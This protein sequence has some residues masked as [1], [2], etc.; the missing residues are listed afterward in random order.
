[1]WVFRLFRRSKVADDLAGTIE[2][3]EPLLQGRGV[4]GIAGE[5][6]RNQLHLLVRRVVEREQARRRLDEAFD[7][8]VVVEIDVHLAQDAQR[9]RG[10]LE[11]DDRDGIAVDVAQPAQGRRRP[12]VEA[13]LDD[14]DVMALARPQH[15]A[16]G[17]ERDGLPVMILRVVDDADALHGAVASG[18]MT[19]SSPRSLA[20]RVRPHYRTTSDGCDGQASVDT[21]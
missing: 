2:I 3:V 18:M 11:I 15:G 14:V 20:R 12:D 5:A 8:I 17:P 21:G 13:R 7:R 9:P 16:M 1:M 19:T 10:L 4:V 6:V